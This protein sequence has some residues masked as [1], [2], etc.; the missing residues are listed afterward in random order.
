[1]N[2]V[3]GIVKVQ[4]MGKNRDG[5][6][7]FFVYLPRKV[8]RELKVFPK[9][10]LCYSFFIAEEPKEP[11]IAPEIV[12]PVLNEQ[13][14]DFIRKLRNTP[15]S[16]KFYLKNQAIQEFGKD[17]VNFILKNSKPKENNH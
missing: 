1:M 13:E 6:D 17:R 15:E 3:S 10:K 4:Q 11:Q 12:D 9:K 5:I 14:K 2:V 16:A 8:A 7:R